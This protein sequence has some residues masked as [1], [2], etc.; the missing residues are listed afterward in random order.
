M[1]EALR[2]VAAAG[3]EGARKAVDAGAV[4]ARQWVDDSS[5]ARWRALEGVTG[6]L[7]ARQDLFRQWFARRARRR[8]G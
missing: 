5:A 4:A 1:G 3:A 7:D 6:L 8:S 2:R